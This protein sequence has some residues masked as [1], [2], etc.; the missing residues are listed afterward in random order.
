MN[1]VKA[2]NIIREF[3]PWKN[4]LKGNTALMPP[5]DL[6]KL[7]LLYDTGIEHPSFNLEVWGEKKFNEICPGKE[8]YRGFKKILK[9]Y[10]F[11]IKNYYGEGA[12]WCNFVA[13]INNLNEL[14]EGFTHMAN[15]GVIPG[16][17]IFHPDQGAILGKS[18]KSPSYEYIIELYHHAAELYHE[19]GYKPFFNES[20]LRNSLANE[21]FNG[22]I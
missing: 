15:K 10:D 17:N 21:A 20:S 14:K 8:K 7:G 6:K 3:S 11:A 4:K 9:A 16:A 1:H 13:G 2:L 19:K 22:W 12:L 5:L 18:L